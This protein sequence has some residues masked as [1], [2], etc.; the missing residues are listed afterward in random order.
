[1]PECAHCLNPRERAISV[2]G[3]VRQTKG[4]AEGDVSDQVSGSGLGRP[5]SLQ[6][7]RIGSR[8]NSRY[9]NFS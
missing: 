3:T 9:R 7:S 2:A 6:S 5:A 4:V 8:G 1:M